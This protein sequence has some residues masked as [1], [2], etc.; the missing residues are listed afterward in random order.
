MAKATLKIVTPRVINYVFTEDGKQ[1]SVRDLDE[2]TLR[3][4]GA[5]WTEKLV[6]HA[7]SKP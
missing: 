3:E 2:Q 6:Q 4:I 5:E 7:K 1:I